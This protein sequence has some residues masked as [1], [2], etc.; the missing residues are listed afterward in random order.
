MGCDDG[1]GFVARGGGESDGGATEH[2]DI[3]E[4]RKDNNRNDHETYGGD[5]EYYTNLCIL[6]ITI[7]R[8]FHC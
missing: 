1:A 8:S 4:V 3:F 2:G 6:L 5:K 7:V